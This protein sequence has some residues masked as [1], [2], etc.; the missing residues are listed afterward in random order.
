MLPKCLRG[1]A[2]RW[3]RDLPESSNLR[4]PSRTLKIWLSALEIQFKKAKQIAEPPQQI[5]SQTTPNPAYYHK[6]TACSASFSSLSRL[7]S[8]GQSASCSKASCNYCDAIFNFKNKLHKHIRECHSASKG[9]ITSKV[10][11]APLFIHQ[12]TSKHSNGDHCCLKGEID[13]KGLALSSESI[14][15][16]S[17]C[18]VNPVSALETSVI[19]LATS[20]ATPPPTYRAISPGPPAYQSIKPRD[21]LTLDD[22]FMRYVSLKRI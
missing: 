7:L 11:L 16:I 6:C 13:K 20:S 9:K 1:P 17:I 4:S 19:S 8:H 21:Y 3:C 5:A 12:K 18:S 2:Y 10:T 22:L 14:T 15:A